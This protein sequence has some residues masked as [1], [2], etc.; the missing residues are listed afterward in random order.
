MIE[1]KR[2]FPEC[3]ADTLLVE[4][5]LQ[6]GKPAHYKGNSKVAKA[7][8]NI[9]NE[10]LLVIGIVDSDKFENTPPYLENFSQTVEDCSEIENLILKKIPNTKKHLIFVCPKFEPWIWKRAMESSIN[11]VDFGFETL[12]DLFK[13]SKSNELREDANF[14][15]FVNAVVRSDNP[16]ILKLKGWLENVFEQK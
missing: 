12:S 5:I 15:K 6:K 8:E 2:I 9:T 16:A 1:V 3:N 13:S 14:K 10:T 4:L 7:L 11:P